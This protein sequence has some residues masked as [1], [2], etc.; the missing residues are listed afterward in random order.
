MR[1]AVLGLG[2]MGRALAARALDGGHR[3]TV[4]N[5]S[6]GR[7]AGLVAGGAVEAASGAAAVGEAELVLVVL[8]DDAAV[9]EVCLGEDGV[10]AA[11]GPTAVLAN[12]ST[13]APDT[14]RQLAAA[15]PVGRVLDAPVMGA[16]AAIA[17]GQGRFLV[18]GPPEPVAGLAP[19]WRQLAAGHQHCGPAGSGATMKLVSNLQL[20][21]GVA[22]LAEG[23]AIARRHGISDPLLREVFADSAV[24]S[25]ATTQRLEPLLDD[26]H[27]GWFSPALARKDIRLAIELADQG[28]V[29]VR[30]GPAVEG[31]LATVA[32][33]GRDWPDFAAVIEALR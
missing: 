15:G 5:R 14:A 10:L 28:G 32:E 4:W 21:V 23:I 1:I 11:L 24:L 17:R 2:A 33:G 16:P 30:L 7:A 9:R 8:A 6:R 18:G 19:L 25:P 26:G 22:A 20:I 27:P 29:P 12:V 31:L 3:V 13:V